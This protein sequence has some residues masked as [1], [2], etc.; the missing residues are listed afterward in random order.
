[1]ERCPLVSVFESNG[2]TWPLNYLATDRHEQALDS[3]PRDIS[4]DWIRPDSHESSAML[5]VHNNNDSISP[6]FCKRG[7]GGPETR[8]VGLTATGTVKS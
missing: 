7:A 3:I 4:I 1:M 6:I 2:G 5:A 8:R